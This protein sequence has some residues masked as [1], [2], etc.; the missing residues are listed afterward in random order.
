[1]AISARQTGVPCRNDR[2]SVQTTQGDTTPWQ[3]RPRTWEIWLWRPQYWSKRQRKWVA[4]T[5]NHRARHE[6]GHRVDAISAIIALAPNPDC[7][8]QIGFVVFPEPIPVVGIQLLASF[9]LCLGFPLPGQAIPN[10]AGG[11]VTFPVRHLSPVLQADK[12]AS[13]CSWIASV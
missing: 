3:P 9:L 12:L 6:I 7:A 10:L 5:P 13:P 1:M 4:S 11:P 2:A 8:N